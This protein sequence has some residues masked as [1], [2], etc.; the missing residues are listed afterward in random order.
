VDDPVVRALRGQRGLPRLN[1]P[2]LAQAQQD[3][4]ARPISPGTLHPTPAGEAACSTLAGPSADALDERAP[5]YSFLSPAREPGEMGWLGPYRVLRV[6]G[7]GGMGVVLQG[8]DVRLQRRVALKVMKPLLAAEPVA[9]A[10]FLREARATAALEHDH[11]IAIHQIDEANGVPYLAMPLL[12]GE[13]LEDRLRRDDPLPLAEVVRI[14]RQTASGLAAAHTKGLIHRDVKPANL[15]L[16]APS[17]RVKILDFGLASMPSA[18]G[19]KTLPGTLLGTPGYMAPEQADGEADHRA[20][21]FSLGC[22]L[23]RLATGRNP[24]KGETVAQKLRSTLLD[25]PEPP[26]Q[27]NPALPGPLCHLILKLLAR[28]RDERPANAVAVMRVLEA[29]EEKLRSAAK[30]PAAVPVAARPAVRPAVDATVPVAIPLPATP[31]T[32]TAAPG[33]RPL[34]WRWRLL[35]GGIAAGVLVLVVVLLAS[36]GKRPEE[37]AGLA[38]PK[39]KD[40]T[41]A[42]SGRRGK[43]PRRQ[44]EGSP[45]AAEVSPDRS[46][47]ETW[48]LRPV[49]IEG[50]KGWS[51]ETNDVEQIYPVDF[52]FTGDE[53]LLIR[54]FTR[55]GTPL[56]WMQFDPKTCGLVQAPFDGSYNSLASDARMC[57]RVVTGGVELWEPGAVRAANT[58]RSPGSP[59]EAAF[60]PGGKLLVTFNLNGAWKELWFWDAREGSKLAVCSP[61]DFAP[62]PLVRGWSPDGKTLAVGAGNQI[63]LF[64]SPWKEIARTIPRPQSVS[65]LAWS[66][67]SRSLATLEADGHVHVIDVERG[68]SVLDVPGPK[69]TCAPAWEPEGTELAFA[70]DE[71]KVVVWNLEKKKITSTFTGHTRA[72][73]AV[74]FLGDG[75]TLVS[76]SLAD[77]RF[78][79]LEKDRLRGTLLHLAGNGWLALSPEGYYRCS[80]GGESR[81]VFKVREKDNRLREFAPDDFRKL[82]GW[83]NRPEMVKLTDE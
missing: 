12:Q 43:H 37:T 46:F 52:D 35:G 78:W 59:H 2:L 68:E 71:K 10:R 80:D 50:L 21:L 76:G 32:P 9:R 19:A 66:P 40:Q 81:F 55:P 34:P 3:V 82:Y 18:E 42:T 27:I 36:S 45:P 51:V 49:P 6:L 24:F 74:A 22:V 64:R 54:Y 44:P 1:N 29:I 77:V 58:L 61:P 31:A 15:W 41:T 14:G 13:T 56:R 20:D 23:Y 73:N 4:R 70:T 60:A 16:E 65:R 25:D 83:K 62:N 75:K 47:P 30:P 48:V 39:D 11:I 79:D 33:P 72:V 63:A 38:G 57:A 69:A 5:T 7:E 26:Q 67:D 53:R 28:E 8:E 17:G